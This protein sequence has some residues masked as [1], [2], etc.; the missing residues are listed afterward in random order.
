MTDQVIEILFDY[1]TLGT[2]VKIEIT[3]GTN[4]IINFVEVEIYTLDWINNVSNVIEIQKGK[5]LFKISDTL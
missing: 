3:E 2:F 4:N 1:P 5:I